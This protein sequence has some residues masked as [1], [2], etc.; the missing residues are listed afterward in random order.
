M[1]KLLVI[2]WLAFLA[3]V[4]YNHSTSA[5]TQTNSEPDFVIPSIIIEELFD[6]QREM[7]RIKHEM[8]SIDSI[9]ERI[10]KSFQD[11]QIVA[12]LI[13]VK[14]N[15]LQVPKLTCDSILFDSISEKAYQLVN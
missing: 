3:G 15:L 8:D 11:L 13:P 14:V 4:V 7:W 1:K 10:E 2:I 5:Q 12:P 6:R 9:N